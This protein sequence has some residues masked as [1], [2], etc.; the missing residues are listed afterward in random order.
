MGQKVNPHGMRVGVNKDWSSK[1]YADKSNF[2]DLLVEDNQIRTFVKK[3]LY[4]AGV[5][6][7]VIE[8]KGAEVKVVVMCARPGMVIG[9]S[10]ETWHGH[11][12]IGRGNRRIQEGAR[13]DDRQEGRR[14]H[15]GSQKS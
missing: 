2:A 10:G 14:K 8:R 4:N 3:K 13:Q 9:R 5:S 12:K 1:W 15:R 11:R 7:V 6:N